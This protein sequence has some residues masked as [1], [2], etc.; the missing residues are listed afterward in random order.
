MNAEKTNGERVKAPELP[1][2]F[3]RDPAPGAAK[4]RWWVW[5]LVIAVVAGGGYAAYRFLISPRFAQADAKA[6]DKSGPRS[7]PVVAAKTHRGDL[8]IY[9]TGLGSVTPLNTVTVHT[10]VDGQLMNVAYTEGQLVKEGELLAEIDPRPF[11]VQLTEAQ[12]QQARDQASL[13]NAKA[14]L[15][16]DAEARSAISQQQYD[17]HKAMVAQFEGAVKSDQGQIDNANLQLTYSKVTAPLSGKI[18]L[19]LVDQG[20]IVHANDPNG[21]AV[22]TQVQPIA[23]VFSLPED[24]IGQVV[25]R[26]DADPKVKLPVDAYNRDLTEKIAAGVLEAVDSQIDPTTGT[27]RLKARFDNKDDELF[28]NQFVNARL[29]VDT[30]QGA[31][32]APTAAVQRGPNNSTFVYVVKPSAPKTDGAKPDAPN[33]AAG[34]AAKADTAKADAAKPDSANADHAQGGDHAQGAGRG[35]A[36]KPE[37]VAE[38]RNVVLGPSEGDQT[39]I[40]SGVEPGE[41]VVVDGV[42][43]LQQGMTVVIT[44]AKPA[45]T[46]PA[47]QPSHAGRSNAGRSHAAAAGG[48]DATPGS[49]TAPAAGDARAT[50]SGRPPNE[51]GQDC[52]PPAAPSPAGRR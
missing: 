13:D 51:S 35:D 21:L 36:P 7:V 30:I 31:V 17:T 19:R 26:M 4:S 44:M 15:S 28:P 25:R 8:D 16:R 52:E 38:L 48:T 46:R 29:L 3:A 37:G 11:Q 9:L 49:T 14:N 18:G 6:S 47:T 27:V 45:T 1:P 40:E 34:D 43:K 41:I 33:A 42:D 39:V 10:R 12:G 2:D 50:T 23:V 24:D 32:L 20:N 5:L 22:I